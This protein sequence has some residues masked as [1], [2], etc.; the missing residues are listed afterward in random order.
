MLCTL[1]HCWCTTTV[2]RKPLIECTAS[3]YGLGAALSRVMED[4]SERPV[5]CA[6]RTLSSA[7]KKIIQAGK[8]RVGHSIWCYQFHIFLY[9]RQFII[10]SDHQSLSYL[11]KEFKQVPPLASSQIQ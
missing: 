11:L 5:T 6:S 9:G 10:E 1:T 2:Q 3:Q 7:E 4:G 8:K